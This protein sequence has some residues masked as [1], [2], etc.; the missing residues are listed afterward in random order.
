MKK[1]D[2]GSITTVG[3]A[4]VHVGDKYCALL[5]GEYFKKG[6][7]VEVV[8]VGP[9]KVTFRAPTV[10]VSMLPADFLNAFTPVL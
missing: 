10:Q 5:K 3:H 9:N 4:A 7:T 2:L 1:M 8:Y 6:D